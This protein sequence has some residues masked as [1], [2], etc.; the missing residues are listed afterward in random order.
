MECKELY[1]HLVDLQVYLMFQ[2]PLNNFAENEAN[3]MNRSQI[4][5]KLTE[6]KQL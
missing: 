2:F 3:D 4:T 5:D 6:L 1:E